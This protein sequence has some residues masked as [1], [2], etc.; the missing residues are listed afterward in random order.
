MQG[1]PTGAHQ[2]AIV[3]VATKL[4]IFLAATFYDGHM[5]LTV[6][7]FVVCDPAT[8]SSW[9]NRLMLQIVKYV[10]EMRYQAT[11]IDDLHNPRGIAVFHGHLYYAQPEYEMVTEYDLGRDTSRVLRRNIFVDNKLQVFYQR[12]KAGIIL[13]F[14]F[15]FRAVGH[16]FCWACTCNIIG[17]SQNYYLEALI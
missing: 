5:T 8:L 16:I 3:V 7:S 1:P 12:H 11:L 10:L 13:Q 2:I 17:I 6:A 15:H 9:F 4:I 14:C